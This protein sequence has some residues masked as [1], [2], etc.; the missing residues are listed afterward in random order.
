MRKR[1]LTAGLLVFPVSVLVSGSSARFRN[2]DRHR[3]RQRRRCQ[4]PFLPLAANP[5]LIL[6]KTKKSSN[7]VTLVLSVSLSVFQTSDLV[8]NAPEPGTLALLVLGGVALLRRI[9]NP[10]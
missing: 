1:G 7:R 6:L 9:R 5:W 8:I 3:Q 2:E 10:L 4:S